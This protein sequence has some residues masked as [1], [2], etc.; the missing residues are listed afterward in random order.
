MPVL[1]RILEA[2]GLCTVLVTNMP[3]WAEKIGVPRVLAV[4][5]P[6]GHTL[7]RPGDAQQQMRIVRQAL[8]VLERAAEPGTIVAS[9]EM[10][11]EP[12]EEAIR[13][14]QPDKP[15]PIIGAMAPKILSALRKR[16]KSQKKSQPPGG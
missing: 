15:S 4:E 5:F 10:W 13:R 12:V 1:A 2:A 7:G 16:R 11:P 14:W 9:P 8:A 6:Y 3:F